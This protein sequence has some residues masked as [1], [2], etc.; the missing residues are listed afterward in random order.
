MSGALHLRF[1]SVVVAGF[2]E[3]DCQAGLLKRTD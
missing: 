3:E 2:A 1:P